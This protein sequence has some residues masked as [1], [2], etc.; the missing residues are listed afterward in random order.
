MPSVPKAVAARLSV[1]SSTR[2]SNGR[3]PTTGSG[4]ESRV[5]VTEQPIRGAYWAVQPLAGPPA[6]I[7]VSA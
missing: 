7:V 1:V 4:G 5:G 2:Q 3:T 6:W